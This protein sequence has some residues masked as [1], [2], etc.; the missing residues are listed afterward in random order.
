MAGKIGLS[1]RNASAVQANL[2][3]YGDDVRQAAVA[4]MEESAERAYQTAY[5]LAPKRT[6]FMA[7]QLRKEFTP[8]RFGYRVGFREAD[9]GSNFYP[10]YVIFGTRYQTAQDFLFAPFESEKARVKQ[11][12]KAVLRP[13]RSGRRAA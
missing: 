4:V 10:P 13:R 1:V 12:L 2:R 7:N 3:Q 5:G 11:E 6:G 8:Q 9:F